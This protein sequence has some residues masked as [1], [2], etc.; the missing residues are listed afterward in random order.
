MEILNNIYQKISIF[1]SYLQSPVYEGKI[2]YPETSQGA[3]FTYD[4]KGMFLEKTAFFIK[5]E[6]INLKFLTALLNSNLITFY[7]KSFCG[8]ALLGNKG[9]Q[10][11]KHALEKLPIPKIN[12]KN[13]KRADELVNLVDEILSLKERDKTADTKELENK[14]DNLV[15]RLYGL[16]ETE[17]KIINN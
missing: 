5:S 7:F 3:Y 16:N 12:A 14:I 2:I 13:Q 17:I 9:Y 6:S 11:N 8:G 1:L 15:Y 4:D 10:Y